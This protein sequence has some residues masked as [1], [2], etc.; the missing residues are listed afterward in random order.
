MKLGKMFLFAALLA[1][2]C[3]SAFG[4]STTM[5]VNVPFDFVV[6]GK[7]M[8]AGHYM[9]V[10]VWKDAL[11]AWR[12]T[13]DSNNASVTM[14]TNEAESPVQ[15]HNRGL[16]FLQTGGQKVLVEFW[17]GQ[18][19]GRDMPWSSVKPTFVADNGN[20]RLEIAAQ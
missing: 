18:H 13:N 10:P 3:V 12:I 9:V 16:V 19:T 17:T 15:S 2:A 8:P 4:Q 7:L 1:V 6:D 14:L 20:K 5:R 11:K